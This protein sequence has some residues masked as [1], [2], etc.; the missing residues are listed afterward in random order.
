MAKHINLYLFGDQTFNAINQ[1]TSLLQARDNH[2]L[3]V[4]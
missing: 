1:L 2:V 3:D 4:Y